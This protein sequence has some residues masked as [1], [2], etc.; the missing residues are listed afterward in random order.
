MKKTALLAIVFFLYIQPA[1]SQELPSFSPASPQATSLG[2]FGQ[3]PVGMFTGTIQHSIPLFEIE[4][5]NYKLPISLSYSS[6]GINIDKFASSVGMEWNLNAGGVITRIMYDEADEYYRV[7]LPDYTFGS[8]QMNGF[9]SGVMNSNYDTQPDI[10]AFNIN[11]YSGKFYLDVNMTPIQISPTA[12]KIEK[13]VNIDSSDNTLDFKLTTPD[14]VVYWFGG[15]NAT[16]F[17]HSRSDDLGAAGHSAPSERIDVAWYL[18]KIDLLNGEEILFN[19]INNNFNYNSGISQIVSAS[20]SFASGSGSVFYPA[21][22]NEPIINKSY[23]SISNISN[24]IWSNG[25]LEFSYSHRNTGT[26]L[27]KKIDNIKLYTKNDNL[28]SGYNLKYLST[29]SDN[30]YSNIGSETNSKRLFLESITPFDK[31]LIESSAHSFEYYAPYDLPPRLSFARDYWGHFNGVNNHYLVPND[32]SYFLPSDYD[33][34]PFTYDEVQYLFRNVGGDR[35]PNGIYG[36]KGLLK[37]IN[38]PTKGSNTFIYEPHSYYGEITVLGDSIYEST[39]IQTGLH[40]THR[41]HYP[42]CFIWESIGK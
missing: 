7:S 3:V 11:G 37:K 10:F 24:I 29:E 22:Q 26:G 15:I 38:Y 1:L 32:V 27:L 17:S 39:T 35:K 13:I 36:V 40:T 19:Y 25:K 2:N 28:I 14:G 9:L 12:L 6:N 23:T 41:P 33:E 30:T 20:Y 5:S 4:Q 34:P 31:N 21:Q 16:E 18:S 8:D 42:L